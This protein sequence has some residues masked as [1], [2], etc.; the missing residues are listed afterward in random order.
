MNDSS[1]IER[2]AER[3]NTVRYLPPVRMHKARHS[4]PSERYKKRKKEF[5]SK[6]WNLKRNRWTYGRLILFYE[7]LS[8]V[9]VVRKPPLRSPPP[10][11]GGKFKWRRGWDGNAFLFA[12]GVCFRA[13]VWVNAAGNFGVAWVR[14]VSGFEN[15]MFYFSNFSAAFH[16]SKYFILLFSRLNDLFGDELLTFRWIFRTAGSNFP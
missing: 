7:V 3:V 8:R 15:R 11:W 1:Q 6:I 12:R 9:S 4:N 5:T 16:Y 14:S 10:L 2:V 13:F